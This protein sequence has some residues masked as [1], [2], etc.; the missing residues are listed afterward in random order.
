MESTVTKMDKLIILGVCFSALY[1][2]HSG[3]VAIEHEQTFE[4]NLK[5]HAKYGDDKARLKLIHIPKTG[6]TSIFF[7]FKEHGFIVDEKYFNWKF[8]RHENGF[9][10]LKCSEVDCPEEDC[11]S[12]STWHC[13]PRVATTLSFTVFR[14]PYSRLLSEFY[15]ENK[16]LLKKE[17]VSLMKSYISKRRICTCA[18]YKR[19]IRKSLKNVLK[20]KHYED[21]HFLPQFNFLRGASIVLR[22]EKLYDDFRRCIRSINGFENVTLN[23]IEGHTGD[24]ACKS[25]NLNIC[26]TSDSSLRQKI[27]QYYERDFEI[28]D[29]LA[30][31]ENTNCEIVKPI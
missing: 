13:P 7:S 29:R 8:G 27:Q 4:P 28:Y 16:N 12:C 30:N 10:N 21:C 23:H 22:F 15:E 1:L 5:V 18:F 17:R 20:N 31:I 9:P 11:P 6:G 3:F 26:L 2:V 24:E 19:W 25:Q 14:E